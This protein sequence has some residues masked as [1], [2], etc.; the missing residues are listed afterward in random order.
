M[1]KRK[2]KRQRLCGISPCR[3]Y[4]GGA[5]L[6]ANPL[7]SVTQE[8]I[9]DSKTS[10]TTRFTAPNTSTTDIGTLEA[11]GTSEVS[12]Y[13]SGTIIDKRIIE[14]TPSGNGD[15]S[16]VLQMTPNASE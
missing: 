5:I 8:V 6:V 16:S 13:E 10:Q 12:E 4:V 3:I 7:N 9:I 1:Q 2:H 14:S 11:K 15:I